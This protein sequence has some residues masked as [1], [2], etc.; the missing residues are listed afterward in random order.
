MPS[1]TDRTENGDVTLQSLGL[2]TCKQA[3]ALQGWSIKNHRG[4][5]D[6]LKIT[7][8][9]GKVVFIKRIWQSDPKNARRS[10]YKRWTV[11]SLCRQEFENYTALRRAG[12]GTARPVGYGEQVGL[13]SERF[14]YIVTEAAD[15]E[16]LDERLAR[17][18]DRHTRRRLL[19]EAGRFVRKV[20]DAGFAFPDMMPRHIYVRGDDQ[21][22]FSL[23]DVARL[24]YGTSIG[25]KLR[26]RDFAV[27]TN[28]APTSLARP[29]D[30]VRLLQG[31]GWREFP[32]LI[33][34]TRKEANRLLNRRRRKED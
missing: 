9:N 18:T 20:H 33:A 6:I 22:S 34:L 15:G 2:A 13:F 5:R 11:W 24:D 14:S 32:N 12:I 31:Y 17:T 26:A 1:R 4:R 7:A 27:M 23:I 19:L 10:F 29:S 30:R 16:P 28:N 3:K 21:L 25:T 8:A